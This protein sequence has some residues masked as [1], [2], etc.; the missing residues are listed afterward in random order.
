M[1]TTTII[2]T[3]AEPGRYT[4]TRKITIGGRAR[5]RKIECRNPAYGCR[6]LDEWQTSLE[7]EALRQVVEEQPLKLAKARKR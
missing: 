3:L 2:E 4:V 7:V 1:N 6:V 5:S